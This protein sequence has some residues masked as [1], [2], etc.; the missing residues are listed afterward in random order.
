[1]KLRLGIVIIVIGLMLFSFFFLVDR[2]S[3][4]QLTQTTM[5][6]LQYQRFPAFLEANHSFPKSL[7]ELPERKGYDNSIQDGWGRDIEYTKTPNGTV[8][9]RSLGK[10]G[11][12][13]GLG[14]NADII[15]TFKGEDTTRQQMLI[16][17]GFIEEY[18]QK[19]HQ[20]PEKL[21]D[22]RFNK[23]FNP[24]NDVWGRGI[25]Y[26][27][28]NS[29]FTLFS[30]G[31]DGQPGGSDDNADTVLKFLIVKSKKGDKSS[32]CT[33]MESRKVGSAHP[34]N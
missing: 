33:T 28:D 20:L 25:K 18:L 31:K 34:A 13:G 3:P 4:Y 12:I 6:V 11:K 32:E 22:L 17:E 10:D 24:T 27:K 8:I 15:V 29:T 1:M 2:A 14:E 5:T 19:Y 16:I 21:S 26:F 9:L 23:W 7:G 30:Y